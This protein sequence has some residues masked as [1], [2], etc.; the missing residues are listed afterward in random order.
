MENCGTPQQPVVLRNMEWTS[1]TDDASAP[2][3][4]RAT[5]AALLQDSRLELRYDHSRGEYQLGIAAGR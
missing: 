4:R 5:G 1:V 3:L 2:I